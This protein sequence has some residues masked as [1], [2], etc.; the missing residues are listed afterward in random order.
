MC[1]Y[2]F[3]ASAEKASAGDVTGAGYLGAC[4]IFRGRDSA[5]TTV[6]GRLSAGDVDRALEHGIEHRFG[7]PASERVLLTGVEAAE[8]GVRP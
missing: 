4:R 2:P 1:Y 6:G 3:P 7:E 5:G 8:Q